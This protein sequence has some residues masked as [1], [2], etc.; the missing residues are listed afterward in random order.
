MCFLLSQSYEALFLILL[1]TSHPSL[2]L[3]QAWNALVNTLHT[4]VWCG[5]I[6]QVQ[7]F[8]IINFFISFSATYAAAVL[9]RMSEDKGGEYTKRLSQELRSS[10]YQRGQ[11]ENLWGGDHLPPND[12]Q[13]SPRL[14]NQCEWILSFLKLQIWNWNRLSK[15]CWR[16]ILYNS[17][18]FLYTLLNSFSASQK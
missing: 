18:N 7:N 6:D 11:E 9:F 4:V 1:D 3:K 15:I 17:T 5:V 14:L 2:D 13:V 16:I 12:L 8:Y 10:L